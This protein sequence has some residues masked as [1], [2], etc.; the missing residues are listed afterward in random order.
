MHKLNYIP[1]CC[2]VQPVRLKAGPRLGEGRVEVLRDGKWGTIVDHMWE[3]TAASVV[4]REL[5]FGTAKDALAGAFMGQGERD[6]YCCS[7]QRFPHNLGRNFW[8][9]LHKFNTFNLVV[10]NL[11]FECLNVFIVHHDLPEKKK[12]EFSSLLLILEAAPVCPDWSD[13]VWECLFVCLSLYVTLWNC[14]CVDCSISSC[15]YVSPLPRLPAAQTVCTCAYPHSHTKCNTISHSGL[16]W[17]LVT[18]VTDMILVASS[19][20][21]I[22]SLSAVVFFLRFQISSYSDT[23]IQSVSS[24]ASGVHTLTRCENRLPMPQARVYSLIML[25]KM[26]CGM[27]ICWFSCSFDH[28]EDIFACV[29]VVQFTFQP[30][31]VGFL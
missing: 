7:G 1:F 16:C 14:K 31:K 4:C 3:R 21:F 8:K 11:Q 17:H 9:T 12:G 10:L 18:K 20:R 2:F 15:D 13:N 6:H 26:K 28:T 29:G 5:G 23:Q 24:C 25:I 30:L 19:K 22:H 27:T